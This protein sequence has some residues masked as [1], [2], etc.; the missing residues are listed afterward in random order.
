VN[1]TT[2]ARQ[3]DTKLQTIKSTKYKD[4]CVGGGGGAGGNNNNS[5][6]NN[7]NIHGHHNP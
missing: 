4:W 3:R 2:R 7:N 6:N 1:E 5:N